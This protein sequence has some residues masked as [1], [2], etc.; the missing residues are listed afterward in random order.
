MSKDTGRLREPNCPEDFLV[1]KLPISGAH[2]MWVLPNLFYDE[3]CISPDLTAL[4]QV[5]IIAFITDVIYILVFMDNHSFKTI[6]QS[7]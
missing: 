1:Q 2:I 5:E 6:F 4:E 3:H 7:L